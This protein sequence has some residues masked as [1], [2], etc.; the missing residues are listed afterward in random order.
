[1]DPNSQE[2]IDLE[3]YVTSLTPD[4]YKA[5]KEWEQKRIELEKKVGMREEERGWG[6]RLVPPPACRGDSTRENECARGEE[7]SWAASRYCWRRRSQ[8]SR[9]PR[10]ETSP[11]ARACTTRSA[12]PVTG[13]PATA[14]GRPGSTR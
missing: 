11:S 13:Q 2:Y 5:M 7:R 6:G 1:M 9:R 10:A 14:R 8:G 3:T 4:R 12:S